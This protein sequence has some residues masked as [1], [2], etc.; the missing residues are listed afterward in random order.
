MSGID[1]FVRKSLAK[2]VAENGVIDIIMEYIDY[3]EEFKERIRTLKKIR[4]ILCDV[5][6]PY[7]YV[8][9]LSELHKLYN[10]GGYN[11]YTY[12]SYLQHSLSNILKCSH[13]NKFNEY[14]FDNHSDL[15]V[16]YNKFNNFIYLS[17][18]VK[19]IDIQRIKEEHRV[20]INRQMI[21]SPIPIKFTDIGGIDGFLFKWGDGYIFQE[22]T[23]TYEYVEDVKDIISE[24]ESKN[25]FI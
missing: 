12:K 10:C 18:S 22:Y 8:P 19:I 17:D 1:K 15:I 2:Y 23:T 25:N 13:F 5:N 21:F 11:K 7:V 14:L 4:M 24:W 3:E 16:E 9:C 20:S 6:G